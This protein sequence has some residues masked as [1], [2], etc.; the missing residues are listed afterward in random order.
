MIGAG[1]CGNDQT[2]AVFA[3]EALFAGV[4]LVVTLFK[5]FPFIFSIH[6]SLSFL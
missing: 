6:K 1:S 4:G 3:G 5:L 2:T